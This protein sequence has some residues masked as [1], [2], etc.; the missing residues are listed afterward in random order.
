[1][2]KTVGRFSD[3][4]AV[5]G[6]DLEADTETAKIAANI[7]M[8]SLHIQWIQGSQEVAESSFFKINS[9][10]TVL[11]PV[12]EML[13]RHRKTSYAIAARSVVRAGTGHKYWSSYSKNT[14]KDIEDAASKL[15]K[16]LFQPDV[17][18]PIKTLDLPL[19]GTS[20]S[21]DALKVLIDIFA[22]MDGSVDSKKGIEALGED[23]DGSQSLALLR[24]AQKVAGR[25][26]GNDA[27]SL[28]LHPAVYFYTERGKHSRFLFLGVLKAVADA[29]RNNNGKWFQEFS[30]AR[31]TIEKILVER[32][33]VVN[34]GLAN[35]NSRQRIDRV[36][37]LL[38][39]LV[40][41]IKEG[42]KISDQNLLNFLGLS[43]KAGSLQIIDA[44]QGFSDDTKS[45]IFLQDALKGAMRC[46]ICAGYLDASKAISYDHVKPLR[47]GGKGVKDNGQLSHPFCNTGIKG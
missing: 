28:G 33:S 27:P 47:Q 4:K 11:D 20:S 34:Q 6:D 40:K 22:I 39:E 19:G 25:M 38:R 30:H 21:I 12:E 16:L 1:V 7:F 45:A 10:G 2:E 24:R 13:L 8:R 15:N 9:Q 26:T 43:G 44:P 37:N 14:Q 41:S 18:E 23:S 17:K 35:I 42:K 3:F 29:I 46:K 31:K 32:K 5:S 36:S